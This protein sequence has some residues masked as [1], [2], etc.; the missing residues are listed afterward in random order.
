MP[1]VNASVAYNIL[2][3]YTK[4]ED[5]L[6]RALSVEPEDPAITLNYGLLLAERQR[7]NEARKHLLI[8]LES[9]STLAQ[10]AYN[11]A[12]LSAQSNL[13]E[14]LYYISRA[15]QLEPGSPKYGYAYA[16]YALL[17]GNQQLAISTLNDVIN[18]N[19]DYIDAYLMLANIYERSNNPQQAIAVYSKVLKLESIPREYAESIRLRINELSN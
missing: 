9:D 14:A 10:A 16:H 11:L 19:P 7:Y 2:G 13:Q 12:V 3:N 6:L 1:M 15:Y 18:A 4:A 5:N 8:A 17:G